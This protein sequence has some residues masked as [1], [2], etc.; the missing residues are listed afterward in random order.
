MNLIEFKIPI[1]LRM[2]QGRYGKAVEALET[3]LS[4]SKDPNGTVHHDLACC[5]LSLKELARAEHHCREADKIL[6]TKANYKLLTTCLVQQGK[7]IEAMEAF[8][9]AL[10][11]PR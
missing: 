11:Y 6:P 8:R 3:G 9:C 5:Y 4:L 10:R 2:M 7:D 1:V